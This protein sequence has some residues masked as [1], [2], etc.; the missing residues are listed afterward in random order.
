M[1][2][3]A[4]YKS[5][6]RSRRLIR[7]AFTELLREK[8]LDKIT[9]ADIVRR[10][11]I[12]RGTFYAHYSDVRAV[13]GQIEDEIIE[14]MLEIADDAGYRDFCTDPLPALLKVSKTLEENAEFYRTLVNS[15]G[16]GLFMLRLMDVYVEHMMRDDAVPEEVRTSPGF[17]AMVQYYAGGV[18]NTYAAWFRDKIPLTLD[19]IS[20]MLSMGIK[21]GT[22]LILDK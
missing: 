14:K 13:I 11:D 9:V 3:K 12:N 20:L 7:Q 2:Q 22:K 10:A 15:N 19:E 18:V 8:A 21:E 17:I 4:E 1:G 5:A 6:V 16:S